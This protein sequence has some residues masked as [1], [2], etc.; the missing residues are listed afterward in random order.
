MTRWEILEKT[1][2]VLEGKCIPYETYKQIRVIVD[3]IVELED[4]ISKEIEKHKEEIRKLEE[5][6]GK[7]GGRMKNDIRFYFE[8]KNGYMMPIFIQN[9]YRPEQLIE[10]YKLTYIKYE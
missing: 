2:E 1:R 9:P 6:R 10:K 7:K 3:S 5:I 4:P 8:S